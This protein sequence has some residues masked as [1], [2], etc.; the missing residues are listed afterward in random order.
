MSQDIAAVILVLAAAIVPIAL[1]LLTK[2]RARRR[3]TV[4]T[5]SGISTG[6][7]P[8]HLTPAGRRH[9]VRPDTWWLPAL[10]DFASDEDLV[11]SS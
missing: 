7:A 4:R 9:P 5:A 2:L 8:R 3:R 10:G 1:T 11:S 6:Y